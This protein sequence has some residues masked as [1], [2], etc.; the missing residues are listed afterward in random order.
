[1]CFGEACLYNQK[2]EYRQWEK[3]RKRNKERQKSKKE[4]ATN[5]GI[6]GA[7]FEVLGVKYSTIR[8]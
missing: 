2:K 6:E 8:I 7:E 4:R 5:K 1:M 3:Y